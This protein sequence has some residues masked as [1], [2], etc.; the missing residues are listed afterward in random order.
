MKKQVRSPVWQTLPS[1]SRFTFTQHRV[2]VA[3]DE[4]ISTTCSL[5]PDVSP[6][7]HSVLRVRLKKVAKP[8]RRVSRQRLLVHEADH[9]DFGAVRVLDDGGNQPVQF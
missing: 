5:L 3:V 8:V 6:F 9:Q 2:V 1:P 4:Q 7:V